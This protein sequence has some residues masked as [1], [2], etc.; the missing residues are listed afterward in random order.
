MQNRETRAFLTS[1]GLSLIAFF[2]VFLPNLASASSNNPQGVGPSQ[3]GPTLA[4]PETVKVEAYYFYSTSC[5]HCMD[6]LQN[7][8]KPLEAEHPGLLGIKLVELSESVNYEALMKAESE[9][10]ILAGDRDLPVVLIGDQMLNGEQ[11]TRE[12]FVELV[13]A[14]LVRRWHQASGNTRGRS[15]HVGNLPG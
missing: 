15:S 10:G 14:G 5:S 2:S 4:A 13:E 11:Q 7:I 3:T 12:K 8:I 9:F 1:I 6:I